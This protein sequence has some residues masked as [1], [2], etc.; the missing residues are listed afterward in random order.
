MNRAKS[1]N[2][3]AEDPKK[4]EGNRSTVPVEGSQEIPSPKKIII[5]VRD[6]TNEIEEK[7]SNGESKET[8]AP[9]SDHQRKDQEEDT[10]L[11]KEG[12]S[13]GQSEK[14]LEPETDEEEEEEGEI[15]LSTPR[16]TKTKGRKSKK[17]LRDQATYK[18][19]MQGSQLTLEKMLMNPRNTHQKGH[20][21]KGMPTS[22]KS[23]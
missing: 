3:S 23:K 2:Q 7:S 16:R 12:D 15:E 17:E 18:D 21:Q 19:K 20:A 10:T 8:G 11:L 14:E 1:K 5:E 9:S 22:T 6:E 4:G 13:L